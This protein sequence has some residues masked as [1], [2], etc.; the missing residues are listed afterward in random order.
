MH[1]QSDVAPDTLGV[2]VL[3]GGIAVK[4]LDGR[5]VFYN[6]DPEPV[7]SPHQTAPGKHVHVLVTGPDD[8]R[9][10]LMYVD[11]RRT[12]DEILEDSGVG[13]ILLDEGEE[14]PL[15]QGVRV[16]RGSVR[17]EIDVDLAAV[18]GRVFVFEE[19]QFEEFSYEIVADEES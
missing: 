14:T 2:E 7:S 6:G 18:D 17:Y 5:E 10:I 15:F 13:R 16:E 4:Y 11:E 8:T 19:D 1:D 12:D 3:D 9:G